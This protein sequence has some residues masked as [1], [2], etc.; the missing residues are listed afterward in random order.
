MSGSLKKAAGRLTGGLWLRVC[1]TAALCALA[2]LPAHRLA[3]AAFDNTGTPLGEIATVDGIVSGT[4]RMTGG[5]LAFYSGD[6]LVSTDRDLALNFSSGGSLVLCPHSQMQVIA[7]NQ[8]RAMMLAFQAGGTEEPFPIH[9]GDVV[10]TPDWRVQMAGSIQDGDTGVV[11]IATSRRG[12]LCIA[13][14]TQPGAYFRVNQ[15][16]GDASF[17]VP[18][19]NNSVRLVDGQMETASGGCACE[20][21]APAE[22]ARAA[23]PVLTMPRQAGFRGVLDSATSAASSASASS[24]AVASVPATPLP[25]SAPTAVQENPLPPAR[26]KKQHPQDVVG[27]VHSFIH[28]IF[29]R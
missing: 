28:L 20:N 5:R 18:G 12:A 19:Q 3:S 1:A 21:D 22:V 23:S 15:M 7:T 14:N 9:A 6:R 2:A 27:Y 26:T 17:D 25:A 29:G 11:R 13:G 24:S 16:V 8:G 10:M 4:V